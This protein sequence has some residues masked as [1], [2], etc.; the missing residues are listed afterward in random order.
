LIVFQTDGICKANF[1][2]KA[3]VMLA[4]NELMCC[5]AVLCSQCA[6]RLTLHGAYRR[7]CR[8]ETGKRHYGWVAQGHCAVCVCYP[9]ILPDFIM[10]HKHYMTEVIEAVVAE[11]ENGRIIER[12]DGCAADVS[13]MRRWVRQFK[14]RGAAAVGWLLSALFELY[15]RHLNAIKLQNKKLL[16]LLTRLLQEF[17]IPGGSLFGR[18]NIILTTRN[19]GFL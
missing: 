17:T 8:D 15:N 4:A 5:G 1:F 19:C 2:E 12:F 16:E 18:V 6:R 9:S 13:T 10:P 14:T 11:S 3:E 7:H